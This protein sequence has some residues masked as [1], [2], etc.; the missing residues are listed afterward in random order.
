MNSMTT[1][2]LLG[3]A[4][5]SGGL[6]GVIFMTLYQKNRKAGLAMLATAL[7]A[8]LFQLYLLFTLSPWLTAAVFVIYAVIGAVV[9]MK[10]KTKRQVAPGRPYK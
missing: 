6:F 2:M 8:A 5:I 7:L 4:L 3:M 9:A 10:L 1:M